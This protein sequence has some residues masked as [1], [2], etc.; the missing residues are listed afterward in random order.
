[1]LQERCVRGRQ[2]W[3]ASGLPNELPVFVGAFVFQGVRANFGRPFNIPPELHVKAVS[4]RCVE[5]AIAPR[6]C[7]RF[8]AD[9][10]SNG[11]PETVLH[12]S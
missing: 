12:P 3:L 2:R 11:A 1:M 8:A 6:C 5:A 4:S 10:V 7:A 9:Q